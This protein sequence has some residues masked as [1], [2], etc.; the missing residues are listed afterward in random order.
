MGPH[1]KM[2]IYVGY[3]SSSIIK[4]MEPT[5]GDLFMA[6]YANCIFNED[7]FLALGEE[8]QNNSECQEINWD[9]KFVISSDPRTLET[10]L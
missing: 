2:G 9:D 6:W 4:Y 10:K 3:H 5:I 1:K 7:H 8:S